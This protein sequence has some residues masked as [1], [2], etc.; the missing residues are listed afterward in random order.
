MWVLT[1]D[2]RRR[3]GGTCGGVVGTE[4]DGRTRGAGCAPEGGGPSAVGVADYQTPRWIP[5]SR[6]AW[7]ITH[8]GPACGCAAQA[9]WCISQALDGHGVQATT[10]EIASDVKQVG[11]SA[12]AMVQGLAESDVAPEKGVW[13]VTR[14]AQ[15]IEREQSGQ[16]AGAVLW[17]LGKVVAL[18]AVH[19]Q[20]RMLDLDP[21]TSGLPP[22]LL[23]EL[24]Y[25]D[26]ENH[27]AYRGRRL[28]ARLVRPNAA[29]ER[30]VLPEESDWV[31]APNRSGVF[32]SPEV[33]RAPRAF[34]RAER[35]SRFG[36]G[37]RAQLL[38]RVPFARLY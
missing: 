8:R 20:P 16:L 4:P 22:D 29:G 9:A 10:D 21:S 32:D 36:R 37:Y 30:L 28:S 35:S 34:P 13:F 3:R 38:G 33:K 26:Q 1:A 5:E 6:E 19:L 11:A 31:L 12:L 27:I 15:V 18:E 17:G 14:G 25:P 2:R 7:Q 23:N 24:L